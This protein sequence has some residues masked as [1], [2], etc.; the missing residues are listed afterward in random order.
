MFTG[1]IKDVGH[2]S[3]IDDSR[4]DLRFTI[5][6]A[7]DLS[8]IHI[9]ASISCDGCCLT[10]VEKGDDW[11][12]VDASKETLTK[13]ILKQW[14]VQSRINLEASLKVGDELGGHMV[15]GH[16][17]G[18]LS[19]LKI[20]REGDS[21]RVVLSLPENFEKLVASKGSIALN[22]IS[23]TVNEVTDDTF[24][25]NIIPHT[26]MNTNMCAL[27]VGDSMNFEID[28]MARYVARIMGN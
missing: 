13:T 6:T 8:D 2:V 16:V 5:Q 14:T 17:D 9:G 28:T 23:L 22:G 4:G 12:S 1:I 10:V 19:V 24:G 15:S 3:G 25:V 20:K 26:W 18:V 11:F 21:H 27:Q 7:L